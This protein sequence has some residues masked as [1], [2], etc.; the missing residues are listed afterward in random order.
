MKTL[1]TVASASGE[2]AKVYER[3]NVVFVNLGLVALSALLFALSFPN[4]LTMW[5]FYPLAYI[6]LVPLFVVVHRAGWI[7]IF[8][9]GFFAGFVSYV[10]LNYWL[11]AFHPLTI[12]IVPGIY[13]IYFLILLPVMKLA[14]SWFPRYGYLVQLLLWMGFEYLRTLGFLGYSYGIMGY[15]QYLFLPLVRLSAL[16]GVWGVSMLVVFPSTFLGNAL[17]NGFHGAPEF[18]RKHRIDAIVFV[19]IFAGAVVYGLASRVDYSKSREWRVALVQQDVDPWRG[20]LPTYRE[21]LVRSIRQSERAL[22]EHPEIVIWSETSFVPAIDYHMRYRDDPESDTVVQDLLSFM[23]KQPVPYVI[24]NDDGELQSSASGQLRR[25]DY[26]AVLLFKGRTI[27]QTYRKIRLVPFTE[28]FPYRKQLPWIYNALVKADTHFWK[29]GHEYTVFN[30][31][32]V[33]FST[34]ICFED[35]FGYL[36]RQF[37]RHG[38]QVIVNLTNDSWSYSVPASMQHMQMAVFRATENARSVVRS[39]NGGMTT[40]IDPNGKLLELYPAFVEG[41][42]IG[43]VPVYTG[44][45]TLYTDW[46]DWFAELCLWLGLGTLAAGGIFAAIRMKGRNLR[47]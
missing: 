5:G 40:I 45:E 4:L 46:G 30:A 13:A 38:A 39:T 42:M 23:A 11:V 3:L 47:S 35:T 33:K 15:S 31:D 22:K 16:T 37:I 44:R 9:Y 27:A 20:G 36:S 28:N 7:G 34:P 18:L 32:G 6:A 19:V 29:E 8:L 26:N 17:R 24:G 21:S 41:Y 1:Q 43:N 14:D 10:F 2:R 25:V 12:F